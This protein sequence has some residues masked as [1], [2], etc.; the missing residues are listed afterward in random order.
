MSSVLIGGTEKLGKENH[1]ID[2][3]EIRGMVPLAI[4][5]LLLAEI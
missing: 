5:M 3:L 4:A 2:A 1:I